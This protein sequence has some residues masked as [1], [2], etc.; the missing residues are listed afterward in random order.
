MHLF[1]GVGFI[2]G[3][4]RFYKLANKFIKFE[5][6]PVSFIKIKYIKFKVLNQILRKV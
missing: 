6:D 1:L 3:S 2:W 4:R 5:Y